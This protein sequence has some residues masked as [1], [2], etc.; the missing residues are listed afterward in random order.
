MQGILKTDNRQNISVELFFVFFRET[1][2]EWRSFHYAC[3]IKK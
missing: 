1:S 3:R 2:V